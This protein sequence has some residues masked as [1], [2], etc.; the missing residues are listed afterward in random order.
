MK[1]LRPSEIGPE[2]TSTGKVVVF[3][4]S[5]HCHACHDLSKIFY[6]YREQA[7]D[8]VTMIHVNM[9]EDPEPLRYTPGVTK[10]TGWPFTVIY[11]DGRV[12]E[13]WYGITTVQEYYDRLKGGLA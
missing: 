11:R 2:V 3:F 9:G 13:L 1:V 4:T 5:V 6:S 7:G 12:R 8:D 10:I